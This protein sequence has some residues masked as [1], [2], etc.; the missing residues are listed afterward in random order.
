MIRYRDMSPVDLIH[1][2]T[3]VLI[4]NNSHSIY[5]RF[6]DHKVEKAQHITVIIGIKG[7]GGGEM[8]LAPG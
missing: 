4:S 7:H 1:Q 6:L 3:T 2:I 5:L 8:R